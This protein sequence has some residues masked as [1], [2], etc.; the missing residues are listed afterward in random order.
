M[1][2]RGLDDIGFAVEEG[3]ATEEAAGEGLE[4]GAEAGIGGR[5]GMEVEGTPERR[6]SVDS[7]SSQPAFGSGATDLGFLSEKQLRFLGLMRPENVVKSTSM[8]RGK[9]EGGKSNWLSPGVVSY[10][11][12]GTKY[13]PI[14]H[15]NVHL[16]TG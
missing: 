1:D 15:G 5:E 6:P 2:L 3:E 12:C 11:K 7:D 10:I 9:K 8:V 16:F 14:G 4:M 13:M